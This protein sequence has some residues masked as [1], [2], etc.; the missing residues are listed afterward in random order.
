[1]LTS[2]KLTVRASEIRSRL[3][4][5]A[6]LDGEA[7]TPEIRTECDKL[8]GE[9]SGVETQLRAAIIAEDGERKAA[10]TRLDPDAPDAETRALRDLQGRATFGRYLAAYGNQETLTGAEK[11][12]AEHRGLSTAGNVVPWDAML[13]PPGARGVELRADAVTPAPGSGNPVNQSEI[14]QRVFARAAV[15]RLGVM[16]PSVGVGQA[17]YPL[18]G[19]GQSAAFVAKDAAKEAT[20]GAI[21]ANTLGAVRVQARVQFRIEDAMTTM[22][23]ESGLREDI[24]LALADRIDAQVVG[25]GDARVRGFLATAANGGLTAYADPAA[26]VLFADAAEQAARGVDGKYA[27]GEDECAWVIGTAT[28]QKLAALIQANDSTSATER[29]R[30]LLRDFMASA[31]IPAA[32]NTNIQQGILAKLGA[33]DAYNAVCPIWEGMRLIRDEVTDA[34]EGW[35]NVTAVALHNFKVLRPDGFARTK[36]K[37]A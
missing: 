13:P 18:I 5:I 36:L 32:T 28:Y 11:E 7:M 35:I 6:G 16:M 31:N 3:N 4:E 33:M 21:T 8:T 17:S 1:M 34:A 25:E 12:L 26:V 24:V 27:G 15:A 29:L 30:R 37:L 20:A 10:E 23:L 22:G 14:I 2:Q 9:Y 19:T